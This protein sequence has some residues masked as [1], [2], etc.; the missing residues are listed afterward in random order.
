M[1]GIEN[2][3]KEEYDQLEQWFDENCNKEAKEEE[4]R[5]RKEEE[6][7]KLKEEEEA[8]NPKGKKK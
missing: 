6:E 1:K 7:R 5:L 4:E 2:S 3:E 8:K